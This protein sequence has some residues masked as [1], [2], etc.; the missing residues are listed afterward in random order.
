VCHRSL[1]ETAGSNPTGSMD[2]FL[3]LIVACS[4]LEVSASS[5]SL[6]QGSPT[7][8]GVSEFDLETSEI[9]SPRPTG[10]DKP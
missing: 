1:A 9:R 2:V 4:Q 7:E 6:V 8:C 3:F 5:L 10:A